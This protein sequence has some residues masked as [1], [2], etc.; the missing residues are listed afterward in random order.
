MCKNHSAYEKVVFISLFRFLDTQRSLFVFQKHLTK[1]VRV[2]MMCRT[3]AVLDVALRRPL[4][5]SSRHL[6]GDAGPNVNLANK[7]TRMPNWLNMYQFTT[8]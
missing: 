2:K 8:S 3:R 7:Y 6:D 5:I 4:A 1:Y